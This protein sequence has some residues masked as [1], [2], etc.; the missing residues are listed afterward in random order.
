MTL[1]TPSLQKWRDQ[2][3]LGAE[4]FA[5]YLSL[6]FLLPTENAAEAFVEHVSQLP[7]LIRVHQMQ[8]PVDMRCQPELMVANVGFDE[9][10]EQAQKIIDR[11]E[12]APVKYQSVLEIHAA[13]LSSAGRDDPELLMED[14][15]ASV[16]HFNSA[17]S[18][19][20]ESRAIIPVTRG[21]LGG[22]SLIRIYSNAGDPRP[23]MVSDAKTLVV[24]NALAWA[25]SE[26]PI[27]ATVAPK[28]LVASVSEN[29]NASDPW[30]RARVQMR[31]ANASWA[32]GDYSLAILNASLTMEMLTLNIAEGIAKIIGTDESHL[33]RL[34]EE[35]SQ[36]LNYLQK[37][38]G[39]G[40]WSRKDATCPVGSYWS[41]LKKRRDTFV[42]SGI[43]FRKDQAAEGLE[44]VNDFLEFLEG[45]I[46]A[47][48]KV[49]SRFKNLMSWVTS[50]LNK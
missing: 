8:T 9:G 15:M 45:A 40:S 35:H 41:L 44:A 20:T 46:G 29:Y 12:L 11:I 2:I 10:F 32:Y 42:H 37:N 39:G 48:A 43:A 16:N 18:L 27:H 7:M 34:R 38:L 22:V 14:I 13:N 19:A 21:R 50:D 6:P 33:I 47:K 4:T 25:D 24:H 28:A 26:H 31:Q 1:L 36:C 5:I 30:Q 23:E 3:P 17:C 49:D